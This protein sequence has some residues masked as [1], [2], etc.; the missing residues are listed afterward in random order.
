M[1]VS[2]PYRQVSNAAM[3]DWRQSGL[4]RDNPSD[5]GNAPSIM[6][7]EQAPRTRLL[8]SDIKLI[9]TAPWHAPRQRPDTKQKVRQG[10]NCE[11]S[12]RAR[13]SL[14]RVEP[15]RAARPPRTARPFHGKR[16]RGGRG[17]AACRIA[18]RARDPAPRRARH[19]HRAQRSGQGIP[20][21][22]HSAD[23][24]AGR[25][26]GGRRGLSRTRRS[27]A[28]DRALLRGELRRRGCRMAIVVARARRAAARRRQRRRVQRAV[29]AA[30]RGALQAAG[31]APS[32]P[33]AARSAA[34]N[35]SYAAAR[36]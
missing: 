31:A 29:P 17:A 18:S 30:G 36:A 25:S 9:R 7:R 24:R 34:R 2:V 32:P 27:R 13:R 21:R 16:C 12:N 8:T 4:V 11:A 20:R 5:R 6:W 23:P 15:H 3:S 19:A 1:L 33:F 28:L 22:F 14:R 26:A 35:F 10:A